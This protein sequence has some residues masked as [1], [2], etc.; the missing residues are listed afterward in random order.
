MGP[1]SNLGGGLSICLLYS[2][3]YSAQ[4]VGG[5]GPPGPLGDYIPAVMPAKWAGWP[6]LVR[7]QLKRPMYNF[8]NYFSP[9]FVYIHRAKHIIS[10]DMFC[11]PHF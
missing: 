11:L 4:N 10:R 1:W 3:T 5:S 6:V 9:A 8:K 7:W 2:N